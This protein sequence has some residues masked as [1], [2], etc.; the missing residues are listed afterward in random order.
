MT[1]LTFNRLSGLI[2]WLMGWLFVFAS[3]NTYAQYV[4][5][6]EGAGEVKTGYA[7][8]TVTLSELQ[9]NMTEALIG[10]DA[11]DFKN[12]LRSV[13]FNG[14]TGSSMTMLADKP[15]GLGTISF[16]YKRFGTD[17]QVEFIVEYSSNEGL[18]W[19]AIGNPFTAQATDEVQTFSEIVNV[20]GAIRVRIRTLVTNTSNRRLNIDDI[21]MTDYVSAN[22]VATPSFTPNGGT[23][24]NP[25]MVSISTNTADATI[26]Y[27]L[28][29]STPTL[30]SPVYTEAFQLSAT[31]VVKAFAV[32]EGMDNSGIGSA[33]FTFPEITLVNNIADLRQGTQGGTVYR[34]TSEAILSFQHPHRNTKYVQDATAAIVIDDLSGIIQ[35]PYSLYDGITGLTGTLTNFNGL[36]QF[37]PVLD[38]GAATSTANALIPEE[39]TLAG[40]T[41]NDQAKLI[42]IPGLHFGSAG[43]TNFAANT[44][45]AVYD[46]SGSGTFRTPNAAAALN[47]FGQPVPSA[48]LDLVAVV[49]FNN[50]SVQ[51]SA[52]ELND[53]IPSSLYDVTFQ[54]IDGTNPIEDVAITIPLQDNMLTDASG[55]ATT[56]LINGNYTFTASKN[57]YITIE[58]QAFTVNGENLILNVSMTL[59]P[60]VLNI[61]SITAPAPI[62]SV[63]GTPFE[64][65]NLPT[66]LEVLLSDQSTNQLNIS[67]A[68]G[69]YNPNAT[70]VY[71]LT[72]TP[73]LT[74]GIANPDNIT[75][76]IQVS[77]VNLLPRIVENFNNVSTNQLPSGWSG[78]F[79]VIASGGIDNSRRL[80]RNLF[81]STPSAHATT[82]AVQAGPTPILEFKYRV[83]NY[84][85]Y[86]TN[87]VGTPVENFILKVFVSNDL[88]STFTQ[89][90]VS[91]SENHTVS[92]QYVSIPAID[93]SAYA[94]QNIMVKIE[95]ERLNGDFYMD[96]DNFYIG[97]F[98]TPEIAVSPSVIDFGFQP[99][100]GSYQSSIKLENIGGST[101]IINQEDIS[102]LGENGSQFSV[103]EN[104]FPINL[105][106]LEQTQ[107]NITFIPSSAGIKNAALR[108][109][110]NS[111]S[112]P[113]TVQIQAESYEPFTVY[114]ENFDQLTTPALPKGWKALTSG[115]GPIVR[116]TTA[117]SPFS[118]PNQLQLLIGSDLSATAIAVGPKLSNIALNQISFYTKMAISTQT[119]SLEVGVMSNPND[120]S[121]FVARETVSVSGSY[122]R[123]N[124]LLSSE[125]A[126]EDAWVAFRHVPTV[127]SRTIYIDNVDWQA[128][129]TL[130]IA[131]VNPPSKNYGTVAIGYT[132]AAQT[133]NLVNSG[134]ETL[135][136]E[137]GGIALIG[138]GNA[139]FQL[140]LNGL[141]FPVQLDANQSASFQAS[142]APVNEGTFNVNIQITSNAENSALLIPLTGVSY[143]PVLTPEL[144][145]NFNGSFPPQ[146]WS[147]FS[148]LLEAS[149]VLTPSS[150]WAQGAFA[151]A[152]GGS[153]SARVN[154]WSTTARHWLVTPPINLGD[155]TQKYQ[156]EFDLAHTPY[157]GT[158]S[159]SLGPDD[160]FDVVISTDNGQTWSN[161]NVLRNWNASTP[162]SNTGERITIDLAPFTGVVKFGFYGESTI[163]NADTYVFVDNFEVKNRSTAYDVNFVV[164]N[165]ATNTLVSGAAINLGFNNEITDANGQ[166]S[167]NLIPGTYQYSIQAGNFALYQGTVIVSNQNQTLEIALT[168]YYIVSF[169]VTDNQSNPIDDAVVT[170]NN[171]S[172][173]TG[174]YV[175]ENIVPGTYSYS[176]SRAGFITESSVVEIIN[177]NITKEVS[178]NPVPVFSVNFVVTDSNNTP[179]PDAVLTFNGVVMGAGDYVI[180]NVEAGT[181]SYS[182]QK[183]GYITVNGE[184]EIVNANLTIPVQMS[185]IA[186]QTT[187]VVKNSLEQAISGAQVTISGQ[188]TQSTNASGIA[189][190]DNITPGTYAYQIIAQGYASQSGTITVANQNIEESAVLIGNEAEILSYSLSINSQTYPGIIEYDEDYEMYFIR[191]EVPQGTNLNGLVA[192]F[193]TSPMTEVYNAFTEEL[194][195]SGETAN[196][197]E[198]VPVVYLVFAEDGENMNAYFAIVLEQG[199]N[200]EAEFISYTFPQAVGE[201]VIDSQNA[202]IYVEVEE[203]TDLSAL[204]AEFEVSYGAFV[205]AEEDLQISGLSVNNFTEPAIFMVYSHD[206]AIE[207]FWTVYVSIHQTGYSVNF[208]IVDT[209]GNPIEDAILVFNGNAMEAGNYLVEDVAP[210]TY[211]Y[212]IQRSGFLDYAG[213]VEITNQDVTVNVTMQFDGL[214]AHLKN[215]TKV[216]P[217][218]STG[219]FYLELP[220]HL[221]VQIMVFDQLGTLVEKI[222]NP[223]ILTKFNFSEKANGIYSI[224]VVSENNTVVKKVQITK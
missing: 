69:T 218:P 36:I 62:K 105:A 87:P 212:L 134:V 82:I 70:G 133:F 59:A 20:Q 114:S 141:T 44:S 217:N 110:S 197:Y 16:E 119:G 216:Y 164:T 147:R 60:E 54:V 208:N 157:E 9:W 199:I 39:R 154:I 91:N 102:L 66:S 28:D 127:A 3:A 22:T 191:V 223:G 61:V 172:N 30:E 103:S 198:S 65:L 194:Q 78:T 188:G 160:R 64:N 79:Y 83:V 139:N 155:G 56:Q 7:S 50:G 183:A 49:G 2:I 220:A 120:A 140:N 6:F 117:G 145:Q 178:L 51:I 209:D 175:F 52:R 173:A 89:V 11:S 163:T 47:Y 166:A 68:E 55:I 179:I 210:G 35:T 8:G 206:M 76:S 168:P 57:G 129:P 167:M 181:Y 73:I 142:F 88:G 26:H 96:F 45:Y 128:I 75:T 14:K 158:T 130:P 67:W 222:E 122:V 211:A 97:S 214:T 136:V 29:G 12:G 219:V 193:S 176:V 201:A 94:N 84:T 43:K 146:D 34:L 190:F 19:T 184:V 93:I 13:R 150:M 109:A 10:T 149:S 126:N 135:I 159:T 46:G 204:V 81:G 27:T 124:V 92:N 23:F 33:T 4:V 77:L 108:I 202:S 123:H 71:T 143:N 24:Y 112:S 180:E 115:T 15:N 189:V 192:N 152:S 31:A 1:K 32:K 162:I 144:S 40:L 132:S 213:S 107:L 113:D 100:A 125:G 48:A 101:L 165:A 186:Y 17:A 131:N 170:L 25:I 95:G 5:N 86:A 137:E 74:A 171:V 177:A 148:G 121:S 111:S 174:N 138:E 53:F 104:A 215:A 195:I 182:L 153:P 21:V 169:V 203:G 116:T 41:T 151:N 205:V 185:L 106:F 72:G 85:G 118:A 90:F 221:K 18:E 207:K 224:L 196:D 80:S 156:M 200:Y 161:A 187:F 98:N 42:K 58:N 38:P 37:V 63:I 99:V